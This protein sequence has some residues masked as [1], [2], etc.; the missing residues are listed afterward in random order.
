V[1]KLKKNSKKRVALYAIAAVVLIAALYLI[2]R[3]ISGNVIADQTN[4]VQFS[5]EANPDYYSLL[6]P[7]P[8]DFDQIKLMFQTG[9]IRDNPE[10][11]NESYWKQP[12]WFPRYAE[13]FLPALDSTYNDNREPIW[14]V[15]IFDTQIYRR[16]NH[17]WL[18]NP[19]IPSTTGYGTI[20]IK[21]N[22][23]IVKHRFWIRASVGATRHFG[24]ML[25]VD[26][27]A[28]SSLLGSPR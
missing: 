26:Y 11:I 5:R 1:K 14:S 13:S 2:N 6:P 7:K 22:S 18:K 9:I 19:T 28:N 10:R 25:Y 3:P 16:I 15:G 27:P 23:V 21:N 12:E 24:V 4:R 8:S 17:D 20:E